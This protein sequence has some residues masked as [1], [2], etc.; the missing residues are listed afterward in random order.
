MTGG[1]PSAAD[2]DVRTLF[3]EGAIGGLTDGQLLERFVSRRDASAEA[4]F[5]LLVRRHGPLVW[6]VCRRGLDD[7]DAADAF[8]A[9]FLVLVRRAAAVRVEDSL[10]RWLYGV[11]RRVVARARR[12]SAR[13]SAREGRRAGPV[14]APRADPDHA[15]LLAVLDEEIARLPRRYR[16]ALLLCDLGGLSH[17]EAASRLGCAVGTIGSRVSRARERLRDRLV[18]RG[19]APSVGIVGLLAAETASAEPPP[20]MTDAA[21]RLAS[22]V[23]EGAGVTGAASAR[24]ASL[25]DGVLKAMLIGRL[26]LVTSVLIVV[27]TLIGGVRQVGVTALGAPPEKR[28]ASSPPPQERTGRIYMAVSRGAPYDRGYEVVSL[29]P[30]T[31]G[32][33][34]V[35]DNVWIHPRV[36]PDG[37]TVAFLRRGAPNECTVWVRSVA[38]DEQP[39]RILNLEDSVGAS[40]PVWSPDGRQIVVSRGERDEERKSWKTRTLRVNADG[41]DPTDLNLPSGDVVLDWSADGRWFLVFSVGESVRHWRMSVVRPDGSGRL[42][43]S[44]GGNPFY[45]RLSPDSRRVLYTDNG[46]GVP[47]GIWV[48]GIDG[49]DRHRVFASGATETA[50][51]C[52]SPDG[53]RIAIVVVDNDQERRPSE[54]AIR[55]EVMDLDGGHRTHFRT[56]GVPQPTLPD[57]R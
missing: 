57:W 50:T 6:G 17:E 20:A 10:G 35:F 26:K 37:R 25:A 51:G 3:G 40:P 9:T 15:E 43:L 18:R 46:V 28:P 1:R 33:V 41:T 14:P 36:S 2:R 30:K 56:S 4:A 55:V 42:P 16:A 44:D 32:E 54:G 49:G 19:V 34:L 22:K 11:S 53:K 7:H 45:G 12:D 24:I 8:Q 47:G 21:V 38:G 52:W 13:R 29:N 48:V 23:S 5:A 31:G 27:G 39:K